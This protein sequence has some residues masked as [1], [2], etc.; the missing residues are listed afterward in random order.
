M[1]RR[2]H[3]QLR[4]P[5]EPEA[6]VAAWK[7]EPGRREGGIARPGHRPGGQSLPFLEGGGQSRCPAQLES[8]ADA[9]VEFNC[10][11]GPV[12]DKG[13]ADTWLDQSDGG[14]V[15]LRAPGGSRVAVGE[16]GEFA[17]AFP[18]Q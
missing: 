6:T 4:Q 10:G 5:D 3:G 2:N 1:S 13:D 9:G 11:R 8:G 17:V 18:V 15:P 14:E 12:E 16:I 7:L